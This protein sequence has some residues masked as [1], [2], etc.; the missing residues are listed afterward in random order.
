MV[1]EALNLAA[2]GLAEPVAHGLPQMAQEISDEEAASVNARS[3][4]RW[5]GCRSDAGAG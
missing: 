4:A 2:Q 1:M 3:S 5:R